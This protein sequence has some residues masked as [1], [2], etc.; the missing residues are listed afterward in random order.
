ML[1][2]RNC[3]FLSHCLLAQAVR[4]KGLAKYFPAAVK[5]VV[6]FCLD[7]DINMMQMPC[8]E[9]ICAAGGLGRDAHGKG[10]YERNGLRE[11]A[12]KIAAG[13]VAYMKQLLANDF[14]VLAVIGMEFSPACAVSLLN[15]GQ[16]VYHDEG[17]YIEELKRAMAA[18]KIIVPFIGVNQ[19]G[20]KKLGLDLESLLMPTETGNGNIEV[21]G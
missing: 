9:S 19:R 18:E 20:L 5:P 14:R 3:V 6:Q 11:T 12:E 4:A 16:R 13:Q 15:K 7:H 17:I 2:S 8:P 10:W 1:R 21:A